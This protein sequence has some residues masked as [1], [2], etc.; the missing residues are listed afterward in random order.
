MKASELVVGSWYH[1]EYENK[2]NPERSFVGPAKFMTYNEFEKAYEFYSPMSEHENGMVR[3]LFKLKDIKKVTTPLP[4]Y[5]ELY[6]MY[7]NS[8][9][10]RS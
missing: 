4:A 10:I 8:I 1:I 3:M 2:R 5:S 6:T 9:C 7:L